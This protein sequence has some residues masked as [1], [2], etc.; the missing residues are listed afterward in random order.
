M[1]QGQPSF[2][3]KAPEVIRRFYCGAMK[4]DPD[5]CREP[6]KPFRFVIQQWIV[7][8]HGS[9]R[10]RLFRDPYPWNPEFPCRTDGCVD[11]GRENMDV[12]VPVQVIHPDAGSSQCLNLGG[13]FPPDF[14]FKRI[15]APVHQAPM[16]LLFAAK[17]PVRAGDGFQPRTQRPP[18]GQVQMDAE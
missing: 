10:Q 4:L 16:A 15:V 9:C 14:L 12:L 8:I 3:V 1:S 7:S 18:F 11:C 5:G 17:T 6:A 13:K 2:Q